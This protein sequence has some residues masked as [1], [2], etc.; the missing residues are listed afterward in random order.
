MQCFHG[1]QRPRSRQACRWRCLVSHHTKDPRKVHARPLVIRI[2]P[3]LFPRN[4]ALLFPQAFVKVPLSLSGNG[5]SDRGWQPWFK[6]GAYAGVR[7]LTEVEYTLRSAFHDN[8]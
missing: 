5:E 3:E 2:V 8:F 1:L 7:N 4:K 6:N